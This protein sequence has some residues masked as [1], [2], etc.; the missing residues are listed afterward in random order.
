MFG[1]FSIVWDQRENVL[2]IPRVAIVDDDVSESVSWSR[3]ARP[4][5]AR[6]APA[7]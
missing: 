7:M 5:A 1:R 3:T 4:S 2:L 6:F